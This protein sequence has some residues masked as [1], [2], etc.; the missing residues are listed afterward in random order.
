[1]REKETNKQQCELFIEGRVLKIISI[2]KYIPIHT[3]RKF[4]VNLGIL[5]CSPPPTEPYVFEERKPW[6]VN[7][8]IVEVASREELNWLVRK[9][10]ICPIS[11][12][13]SNF[14]I[15][16][17]GIFIIKEVKENFV[18]IDIIGSI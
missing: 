8:V 11:I 18:V 17:K 13:D 12:I 16:G 7:D 5:P 10:D 3:K 6:A 2:G 15:E 4:G 1:M 14:S 9:E